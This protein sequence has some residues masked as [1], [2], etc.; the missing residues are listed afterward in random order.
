MADPGLAPEAWDAVRRAELAALTRG[1]VPYFLADTT[2]GDLQ[3]LDGEL[4]GA[5]A[6]DPVLPQLEARIS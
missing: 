3:T 4:L 6:V 5:G 1:D 2:T